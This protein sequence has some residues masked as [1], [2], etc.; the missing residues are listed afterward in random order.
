MTTKEC[1]QCNESKTLFDFTN[2]KAKCK[3]CIAKNKRDRKANGIVTA[4]KTCI[5]CETKKASIHF[6]G[7]TCKSCY[8]ARGTKVCSACSTEKSLEEFSPHHSWC[9]PCSV[10]KV[11]EYYDAH[12]EWKVCRVCG[13]NKRS[14]MFRK[15]NDTCKSCF[16]LKGTKVC[17][18]CATEKEEGEFYDTRLTCKSCHDAT[19]A[20]YAE[21]R[22]ETINAQARERKRKYKLELIGGESCVKCGISDPLLLDF[23][24]RDRRQKISGVAELLSSSLE[25]AREERS[26]CDVLCTS[27]HII[28][29]HAENNS[30]KHVYATTGQMPSTEVKGWQK[31]RF[32]LEYLLARKCEKCDE[33][34]VRLLEFDHIDPSSKKMCISTMVAVSSMEDLKME[35]LKTRV[36]CRVCHR[37][38]T[39]IQQAE[40]IQQRDALRIQ[41]RS[42]S[43][44][45][46][47]D[48]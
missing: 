28:E 23:A 48:F 24:H 31:R 12:A 6:Y 40:L 41:S 4:K 37:K 3:S 11:K 19:K 15:D 36:L 2:G 35:I 39:S 32:V 1:K 38:H 13:D 33:T 5:E 45:T 30:Y 44:P 17:K 20:N 47:I 27:C 8:T 43:T 9:K 16:E 46:Q 26:K 21:T 18:S 29:T 10:I 34:D 22:R 7:D 25:R 14:S 42:S